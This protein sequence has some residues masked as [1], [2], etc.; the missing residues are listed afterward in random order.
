MKMTDKI[1]N[2]IDTDN[3]IGELTGIPAVDKTIEEY[4]PDVGP[5]YGETAHTLDILG[6]DIQY[7]DG[8]NVDNYA[9]ID[10]FTAIEYNGPVPV[11][12]SIDCKL[13]QLVGHASLYVEG[14]LLK[15]D[16]F[17]KYNSPERLC[18][19][20]GVKLYPALCGT[21]KVREGAHV[22]LCGVMGISLT[23]DKNI[24]DRIKSV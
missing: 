14:K 2:D 15:G 21:I 8:K 19:E 23:V 5:E 1:G 18:I 9:I 10:E 4:N 24:D 13:E 20:E 6:V 11:Y 3:K 22:K 17:I 12:S 16:L 7:L